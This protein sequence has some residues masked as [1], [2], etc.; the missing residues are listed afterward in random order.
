M[1]NI[2]DFFDSIGII[3]DSK[4]SELS[5]DK[6][7]LCTI[8]DDSQSLSGKYTVAYEDTNFIAHSAN[9]IYKTGDFVYIGIPQ[10]DYNN[11]FIISKKLKETELIHQINPLKDF[12]EMKKYEVEHMAITKTSGDVTKTWT[13]I[14]DINRYD[15]VA[16]STTVNSTCNKTYPN[17][18]GLRLGLTVNENANGERPNYTIYTEDFSSAEMSFSNPYKF[19][20]EIEQKILFNI[21]DLN[22]I[23]NMSLTLYCNDILESD[24][25]KIE[26]KNIKISFGCNAKGVQTMPLFI[27]NS[28]SNMDY[29]RGNN[30]KSI[31]ARWV[32]KDSDEQYKSI[33]PTTK[34]IENK[35]RDL[36]ATLIWK[37]KNINGTWENL[38]EQYNNLFEINNLVLN[39]ASNKEEY[40]CE[41]NY[42]LFNMD[43][44]QNY[45]SNLL[46]FTNMQVIDYNDF[47]DE[48][49]LSTSDN[50]IDFTDFYDAS[51]KLV[52]Y[53]AT[54]KQRYIYAET[55]VSLNKLSDLQQDYDKFKISCEWIAPGVQGGKT[56]LE[57]NLDK[58]DMFI[59]NILSIQ[60]D[61]NQKFIYDK[62][63]GRL[64]AELPFKI[65]EMYSMANNNNKIIFNI[66]LKNN[67]DILLKASSTIELNFKKMGLNSSDYIIEISMKDMYNPSE[68]I[69]AIKPGQLVNVEATVYDYNGIQIDIN[70]E[71]L[72]WDWFAKPANKNFLTLR[73]YEGSRV[74]SIQAADDPVDYMDKDL[75]YILYVQYD[76]KT[77]TSPAKS[78][79][80]YFPI[81]INNSGTTPT[82][83]DNIISVYGPNKIVYSPLG[84]DPSLA[85]VAYESILAD[86]SLY[87]GIS[88]K[89][90]VDNTLLDST[91]SETGKRLSGLYPKL[92]KDN[93]N[94]F[95][96]S[97]TSMYLGDLSKC[98]GL[99]GYYI[100][101]DGEDE[102]PVWFQPIV[103]TQ[104]KSSSFVGDWDGSFSL[105]K[106]KNQ[107]MAARLGAGKKN[108]EDNTFSGVVLGDFTEN[109]EPSTTGVYGFDHDEV[110]YALKDDGTAFFG[111]AGTGR[112]NFNGN[113][114]LIYSGNFDGTFYEINTRLSGID[115]KNTQI[116]TLKPF[117]T[118]A[119][120]NE[121]AKN[122]VIYD[123][124]D[125]DNNAPTDDKI[126]ISEKQASTRIQMTQ[127]LKEY[128]SL[129]EKKKEEEEDV[130]QLQITDNNDNSYLPYTQ[131]P[132][133]QLNSDMLKALN[134]ST[135]NKNTILLEYCIIVNNS[136]F[137]NCVTDKNTIKTNETYPVL[138]FSK[139]FMTTLPYGYADGT[140]ILSGK[141]GSKI[142]IQY[143]Q[144][145]TTILDSTK[146]YDHEIRVY[147]NGKYNILL[148]V[149][150]PKDFDFKNQ[151]LSINLLPMFQK[152]YP[153][154]L[155]QPSE[156]DDEDLGL[157]YRTCYDRK[158]IKLIFTNFK[159]SSLGANEKPQPLFSL[160]QDKKYKIALGDAGSSGTFIDLKEGQFITNG[161]IFRGNLQ[162]ESLELIN[163]L[164][165]GDP[166]NDKGDPWLRI[167]P[168]GE[169]FG[170]S[171]LTFP[172]VL[173]GNSLQEIYDQMA[174]NE[175][176]LAEVDRG[177]GECY[178]CVKT[179]DALYSTGMDKNAH[180][181]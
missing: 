70:P 69:F 174:P 114:G 43:T 127:F 3:I 42:Q 94:K 92:F 168:E 150:L 2:Y 180:L 28:D 156:E 111:K 59:D 100:N 24:A 46:T 8:I 77:T 67:D 106:D 178:F 157:E 141:D 29:G 162:A 58:N 89:R 54:T 84:G 34:N 176:A 39:T 116:I 87:S 49:V 30:I 68:K 149:T 64:F 104:R 93:N 14:Q 12:V 88:W 53:T 103:I 102:V 80:E 45:T 125:D 95:W 122:M 65:K 63:T 7:I 140:P 137:Y 66:Y 155:E 90:S 130:P 4:L 98:F 158:D 179:Q 132:Y 143:K 129:L 118:W 175:M 139:N 159:I 147:S 99:L 169:L 60:D 73:N 76:Q 52:D 22:N 145:G 171:I 115:S 138:K 117:P 62:T 56:M 112:I 81:A 75:F 21:K 172:G 72:T 151:S 135:T 61:K 23:E 86:D 144:I 25:E 79:I 181:L 177:S 165:I 15:Y 32:Y 126:V 170:S 121:Y 109:K 37:K 35:L 6:T 128:W 101:Q 91:T 160:E 108:K 74:C 131:V 27:Y 85:Q 166:A 153:L 105:D 16:I 134:L 142:E 55:F 48:I 107:L 110:S 113:A 124:D 10:N 17:G 41:I 78:T 173:Q 148:Q 97:A 9:G 57:I 71:D 19:Q 33:T 44:A 20:G 11:A 136:Q 120:D 31:R 82:G 161:G 13:G 152:N 47:I 1:F 146:D 36:G 40:K 83:K 18:Y 50:I 51:G 96:L 163:E 133:L 164:V 119:Q 5:L 154:D 123:N 26:F 167:T 38:G